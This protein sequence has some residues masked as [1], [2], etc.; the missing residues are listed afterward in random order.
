MS[1]ANLSVVLLVAAMTLTTAAGA[2]DVTVPDPQRAA[3]AQN[4]NPE[5]ADGPV[6]ND[7]Y[8]PHGAANLSGLLIDRTVTMIGKTFFRQFSQIRLDSLLLSDISLTVHERPS[9]R[10]GSLIWITEDNR[11]LYQATL[12]PRLSDVDQYATAAVEQVEQLHLQRKIM[13]ALDNN[14]DLAGDEW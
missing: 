9:A 7:A 13:Q 14:G 6:L 4:D 3:S 12:P 11:I 8:K 10:W 2:Q 1:R 5:G